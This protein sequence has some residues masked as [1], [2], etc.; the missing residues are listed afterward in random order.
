ML[1]T[2]A[3]GFIGSHLTER[4]VSEGAKVRALV[5]YNS[6]NSRG[7]L[8]ESAAASEIA[9]LPGDVR[10]PAFVERAVA[11]ADVVFHLAAL[12]GIPYSYEAPYS[13]V[14][15]NVTG[16]LNILQAALKSGATKVI[17]T[18]TS[19]VYGTAR[20]VPISESH[21]LQAQSPYSATKIAADKLVESFAVSFGLPAVVVR[22]FNT[23]GPRQ[24]ERAII[25]TI[26]A[27][28]LS[29][30]RRL[31]LGNLSP[32]RDLN[33]VSNTV[34]GFLAAATKDAALGR[35]IHFGTGREISIGDL[36]ALIA[37]LCDVDATVE[38]D[39]A[40]ARP[41]GSEVERLIADGSLAETLLGWRPAVSLEDGLARVIDWMRER[42]ELYRP[43]EYVR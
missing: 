23:F 14:D 39:A 10:D 13:Y 9:F 24:S 42:P 38:E 35:A 26:I 41:A 34:D 43:S 3:G 36:A 32:T 37:R 2:G 27:Q 25:P 19:E 33:F 4:L 16:T 40:R 20:Q 11:G 31:R 7:W 12:I 15:V 28:L 6:R 8:D 29:G 18:S 30:S 21:P 17:H 1:V 22:P 5:R